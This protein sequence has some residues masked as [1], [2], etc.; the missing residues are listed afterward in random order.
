MRLDAHRC[1]QVFTRSLL[2]QVL[3]LYTN[4]DDFVMTNLN[5]VGGK[6]LKTIESAQI[7]LP[8]DEEVCLL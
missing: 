4:F 5:D 6:S 3:F 8:K 7:D 2:V 1:F